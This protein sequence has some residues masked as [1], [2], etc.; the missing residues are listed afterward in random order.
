MGG[1]MSSP[2]SE[3][4][5]TE[6]HFDSNSPTTEA[7]LKSDF[8]ASNSSSPS[9]A[10]TMDAPSRHDR[11]PGEQLQAIQKQ[12]LVESGADYKDIFNELQIKPEHHNE[13]VTGI[14]HQIRRGKRLKQ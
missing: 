9:L 7:H 5:G 3:H 12:H 10:S 4:G 11:L 1:T 14:L 13:V 2:A 8:V 6:I